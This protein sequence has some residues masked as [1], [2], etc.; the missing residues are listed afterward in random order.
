M[1][2]VEEVVELEELVVDTLPLVGDNVGLIE[3]E[4][5]CP[6]MGLNVGN[7]LEVGLEVGAADGL[8]EGAN[9]G[10]D[11]GDTEGLFEGASVGV[12]VGLTVTPLQLSIISSAAA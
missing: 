6:T 8:V 2:A 9:E 4:L 11:E 7:E 1:A 5:V 10:D 12:F 3:G